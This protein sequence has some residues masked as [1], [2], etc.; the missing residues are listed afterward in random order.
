MGR[1][2]IVNQCRSFGYMIL[3]GLIA[4]LI[5]EGGRYF[6]LTMSFLSRRC[7]LTA[8]SRLADKKP[9]LK[10]WYDGYRF[11]RETEMYCPWDILQYV[12]DVQV[13]PDQE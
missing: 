4:M 8:L 10:E 5:Q 7:R 6:F 11:G 9:L 2:L 1:L 3:E 12:D 13:D